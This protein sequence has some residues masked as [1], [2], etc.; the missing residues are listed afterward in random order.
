LRFDIP[1]ASSAGLT[2]S[3]D[4]RIEPEGDYRYLEAYISFDNDFNI[5]EDRP[6]R[7]LLDSG[8]A[9]MMNKHDA[10]WCT[11]CSI[12]ILVNFLDDR[13]VYVKAAASPINPILSNRL[14][15]FFLANEGR[16]ECLA[17]TMTAPENDQV[18]HVNN[19]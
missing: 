11:Q 13:R 9:V 1:E 3:I 17:Y 10:R 2:E 12:Y 8:L 6:T 16:T 15:R 4:I 14:K 18:Y 5:I 7:H 19:F